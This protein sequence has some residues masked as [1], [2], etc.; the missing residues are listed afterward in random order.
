VAAACEHYRLA[1]HVKEV[2]SVTDTEKL[3]EILAHFSSHPNVTEGKFFGT[4]CLKA[5]GKAFLVLWKGDMA[6]KLGGEAHSEA[7]QLEGAQLWDKRGK[8]HPFKEWVQIPAVHS[9]TW[10]PFARSAYEYV[11]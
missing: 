9:S 1:Q 2:S 3:D 5:D 8:G 7:L 6:F 4:P 11:V 10:G